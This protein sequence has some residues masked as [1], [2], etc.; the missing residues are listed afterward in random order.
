MSTTRK[1]IAATLFIT[2]SLGGAGVAAVASGQDDTPTPA[3][4]GGTLPVGAEFIEALARRDF[5]AAQARLS[6]E[7]EFKAFT[8]SAGFVDLAGPEAVMTLM[9]E[10]YGTAEGV[11]YLEADRVIQRHHVGYRIRWSSPEEGPMVFQQ[12][13]FYDLDD[14]NRITRLHLV[15]SGDQPAA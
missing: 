3:P 14:Q 12:H 11:E 9:E 8:P 4:A 10:W 1:F 2:L 15:C 6:P 7:I 13:A 5:A